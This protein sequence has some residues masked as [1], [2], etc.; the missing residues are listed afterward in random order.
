MKLHRHVRANYAR[1][2]KLSVEAPALKK[3]QLINVS[4]QKSTGL[5]NVDNTIIGL[6]SGVGLLRNIWGAGTA[7]NQYIRYSPGYSPLS[8]AKPEVPGPRSTGRRIET[9]SRPGQVNLIEGSS[10]LWHA[11]KKLVGKPCWREYPGILVTTRLQ[12]YVS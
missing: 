6:R 7:L 11:S 10:H 5:F 9:P 8:P 1:E 12:T 2:D 3:W 4:L